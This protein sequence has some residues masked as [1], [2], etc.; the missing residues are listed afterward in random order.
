VNADALRHMR[1]RAAWLHYSQGLNQRQ[2][3]HRLKLSRSV[4]QR[5]LKNALDQG[6]VEIKLHDPGC[7]CYQAEFSLIKKFGLSG[8]VVAPLEPGG[9]LKD[10]LAKAAAMWLGLRLRDQMIIAVGMGTTL[11][12]IPAFLRKKSLKGVQIIPLMGTWSK[13]AS[14]SPF[15]LAASLSEALEAECYAIPAPAVADSTT[16]RKLLLSESV[17]KE[18]MALAR[19]AHVALVGLG[20]AS[21]GGSLLKAGYISLE[22]VNQMAAEGAVGELLGRFYGPDGQQLKSRSSGRIIGL[23]LADLRKL[24]NVAGVAGGPEKRQAILGALR[25][26]YIRTLITDLETAESLLDE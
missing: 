7:P 14:Y 26:G 17:I 23:D 10:A 25:G 11:S 15:D 13:R 2:I 4:V 21:D 20:A 24:E 3:A 19:N 1:G 18:A 5:L 22:E 12:G 9:G 6:L 16:T 8:A